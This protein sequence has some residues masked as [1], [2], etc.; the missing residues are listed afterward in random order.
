MRLRPGV[1]PQLQLMGLNGGPI[2]VARV[3]MLDQHSQFALWQAA[4]APLDGAF[5]VDETCASDPV[6]AAP[7][8][9]LQASEAGN[10]P[11]PLRAGKQ[12]ALQPMAARRIEG[13]RPWS[14]MPKR[15]H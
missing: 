8:F 2:N 5:S 15:A 7:Q 3:M 1:G 11:W 6:R 13:E 10:R 14:T 4:D 9:G 12:A